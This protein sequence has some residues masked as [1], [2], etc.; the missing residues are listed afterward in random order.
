[1]NWVVIDVGGN[2][3]RV[4]GGVNYIG[5]RSTSNTST[6]MPITTLPTSGM[7]ETKG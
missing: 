2:D 3:L 5:R 7:Q 6:R 4:I 1:M